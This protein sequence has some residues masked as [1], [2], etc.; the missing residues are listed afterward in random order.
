MDLETP[1]S[2]SLPKQG[3][4]L[5]VEDEDGDARTVA[6]SIG[7]LSCGLRLKRVVDG[8]EA[9]ELLAEIDRGEQEV[10]DLILLDLKLPYASG[11]DVLRRGRGIN[12]LAGTPI[13]ILT[14]S[15]VETDRRQCGELG[16]TEYLVKPMDFLE[17]Q[18]LVQEACIKYVHGC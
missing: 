3:L 12:C 6:R 10:P 1:H 5:H 9:L 16:C 18:R 8:R 15:D 11:M 4:V 17:F 14:S 7:K 13:V 2:E